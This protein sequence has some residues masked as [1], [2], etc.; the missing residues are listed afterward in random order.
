MDLV[1]TAINPNLL[2]GNTGNRN[3]F[4]QVSEI[5]DVRLNREALTKILGIRQ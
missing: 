1:P 3:V 5:K 4:R 2:C